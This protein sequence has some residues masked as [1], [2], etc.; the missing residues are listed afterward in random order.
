MEFVV[1][2]VLF[3]VIMVPLVLGI[4]IPLCR[5]HRNAGGG[6][7]NCDAMMRRFVYR[8]ELSR[9]EIIRLLKAGNDADELCCALGPERDVVEI[10]EYGSSV[11]YHYEIRE[12]DGFFHSSAG[13]GCADFCEQS[14]SLQAQ[15]VHRKQAARGTPPLRAVRRLNSWFT[16]ARRGRPRI[17]ACA[18]SI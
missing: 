17:P 7:V 6:V 8:V 18:T 3:F 4:L 12:C 1:M 10:S 16:P 13:T 5:D 14:G 2:A 11:A 9:E 15:S